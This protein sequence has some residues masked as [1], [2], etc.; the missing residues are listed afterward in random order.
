MEA[1]VSSR[2]VT[3][4]R[5]VKISVNRARGKRD[6]SDARIVVT[7]INILSTSAHAFFTVAVK[8]NEFPPHVAPVS[9]RFTQ[10]PKAPE[11]L[12]KLGTV[13]RFTLLNSV[14]EIDF[15]RLRTNIQGKIHARVERFGK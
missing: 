7:E 6:R 3:I 2:F 5:Y 10:P 15:N 9:F 11:H 1:S 14:N 12:S 4:R 13:A 8:G